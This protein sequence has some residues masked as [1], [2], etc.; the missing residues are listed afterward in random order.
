MVDVFVIVVM[1]IFLVGVIGSEPEKPGRRRGTHRR[2]E[3]RNGPPH[4]CAMP[5]DMASP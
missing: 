1:T 5:A 2:L 4:S 3:P